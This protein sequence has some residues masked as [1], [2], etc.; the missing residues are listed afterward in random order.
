MKHIPVILFL[1]IVLASCQNN[2]KT[3]EKS[4]LTISG[5]IKEFD[6]DI[7]YIKKISAISYNDDSVIDSAFVE[8][9]GDFEFIISESLPVLINISKNGR[10]HPIHEIL[11]KDP[12]KYYYGYCAMFFVPEPTIY[13]T[14]GSNVQL[15]WTVSERLDKYKFG[16]NT[17]TNQINFYNYYLNE[18][19]S[20]SLYQTDGNFKK[21]NPITAWNGIEN[22]INKIRKEYGLNDSNLNNEFNSYLNT[23]IYLGAINMFVNWYEHMF[24][25]ELLEAMEKGELPSQYEN[26][27]SIYENSKWNI[28]SVEYYKMTERFVTFNLNKFHKDFNKFYPTSK[29]KISIAKKVLRPTIADTYINN[30]NMKTQDK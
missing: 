27:F 10:Q 25:E 18:N 30:I 6:G 9:N 1:L 28:Q 12:D 11:R 2:S 14:K 19:I 13:L 20:E 21:M 7:L 5:N 26:I 29:E 23:E 17:I 4:V 15:D 8:K 3:V 16:G 22:A 24:A